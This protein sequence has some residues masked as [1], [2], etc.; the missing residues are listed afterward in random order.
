MRR[1]PLRPA[2]WLAV[3]GL[4]AALAAYAAISE[5]PDAGLLLPKAARVEEVP[6]RLEQAL[7]PRPD[8]YL[9]EE[10]L[11]RGER[12]AEFLSRLGIAAEDAARLLR[13]RELRLVRPG[14]VVLAETRAGGE[15]VELSF[16]G[17]RERLVRI[18]RA[19]AG[20][21]VAEERAPLEPRVQMRS[22]EIR[23][24]LFEAADAGG[25]PD[26]VA[27]QLA[28]IFGGDIDFHRDLRKGDR[29]SVAYETL[30]LRGRTV[31]SGR[32][33]AAEF[34]NQ[35]QPYR[36][37]WFSGAGTGRSAGYYT[38]EGRNLRKAFLRSP[39]EFSRVS[40][41]FGMRRHPFLQTWRQHRGVDYAAPAGTRVRAAGDGT[42]EFAGRSGG[43][44][45]V[46]IVRHAGR[47]STLYAHLSRIGK[48]VRRGARLGQGE[49]VGY[50]GQTGWA[51]G[52]H[53]HYEFRVAGVA[54][55][56]LR[57]ALP[58]ALPVPPQEMAA[59]R[60]QAAPLAQ[61]LE[62]LAGTELARFE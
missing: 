4:P 30:A 55:N 22:A 57:I 39:L 33:L 61:R 3:L 27:L 20:L 48:G 23:S 16:L 11:E 13:R 35:G 60:A 51:T 7:L 50:V 8:R 46:V 38:P 24:S 49:T 29:F 19:G 52:P 56:P 17:A 21:V 40:S 41:G 43:Y 37:V 12:P 2:A 58:A 32:V 5:L 47:H 53:L 9:R 28:D 62:L 10:R 14:T 6:I 44:G 45:N 59:F 18:E 1:L 31:G 15:L 34:V 26:A 42:V 36:A 25:I 54:R